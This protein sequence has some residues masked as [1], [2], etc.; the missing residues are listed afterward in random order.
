MSNQSKSVVEALDKIY[1]ALVVE[2]RSGIYEYPRIANGPVEHVLAFNNDEHIVLKGPN[3][4]PYFSS[5]G[6]LTDLQGNVIPGSRVATSFPV[7]PKRLPDTVIWPPIQ[8]EPIDGPPPPEPGN[9]VYQGF[10]KQAYFFD[11][12]VN[13]F[14]TVGPSIPKIVRTR[15]GGA[16]FWVGSIGLITQGT[17]IY[18]GARGVTTYVGSGYFDH[19]PDSPPEQI[20]LL[21]AGFKAL[22]G[23][24]A[25]IVL[26]ADVAA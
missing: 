17:G 5:H 10:S 1:S 13:S 2:G 18:E 19:W 4:A 15:D 20:K 12:D 16:Q 11:N 24:Y 25:K 9:H 8:E 21:R 3:N 14:V 23:T 6:P 7:D 22:I 26:R